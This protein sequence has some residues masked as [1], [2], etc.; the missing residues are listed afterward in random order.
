MQLW[1]PELQSLTSP[2]YSTSKKSKILLTN[3][4][5][6]QFFLLVNIDTKLKCYNCH[7]NLVLRQIIRY[8]KATKTGR[9]SR[10]QKHIRISGL[11]ICRK[12]LTSPQGV[13]EKEAS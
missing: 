1:K 13:Q 5:L 3:T 6:L 10:F 8:Q 9:G 11:I 7:H 4:K 2:V 12:V